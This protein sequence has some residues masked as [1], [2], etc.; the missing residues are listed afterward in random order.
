MAKRR[1][2]TEQGQELAGV[3]L[4][5]RLQQRAHLAEGARHAGEANRLAAS[6]HRPRPLACRRRPT[7]NLNE[8]NSTTVSTTKSVETNAAGSSL[9]GHGIWPHRF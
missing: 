1:F 4:E 3:N 5:L 8:P 7:A 6:A 9:I 2:R